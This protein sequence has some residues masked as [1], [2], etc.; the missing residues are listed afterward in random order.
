M[1][2]FRVPKHT[3]EEL[4]CIT[5]IAK[6]TGL[7]RQA[8]GLLYNRGIHETEQADA[9][10]QGNVFHDP[11]FL[12]HMEQAVDCIEQALAEKKHITVYAAVLFWRL[13]WRRQGQRLTS[14]S[15]IENRMAMG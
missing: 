8:A 11:F 3:E 10:L 9:F 13:C 4:A 15:R 2:T 12:E 6:H 1:L 7:T 5:R 14:S